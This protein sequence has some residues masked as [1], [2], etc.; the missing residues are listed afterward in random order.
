MLAESRGFLNSPT[1]LVPLNHGD[2]QPDSLDSRMA[3]DSEYGLLHIRGAGC[4]CP[5][6]T[7]NS[8]PS[9]KIQSWCPRSRRYSRFHSLDLLHEAIRLSLEAFQLWEEVF[10][11]P[12]SSGVIIHLF[13]RLTQFTASIFHSTESLR[14]QERKHERYSLLNKASTLVKDTG[15]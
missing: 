8:P 10:P 3:S 15:S 5:N 14:C 6:N 9:F 2:P 13:L 4:R 11:V 1:P 12:R 7:R